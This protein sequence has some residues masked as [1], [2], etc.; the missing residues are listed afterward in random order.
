MANLTLTPTL[1]LSGRGEL[2]RRERGNKEE[3]R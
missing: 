1:S 2:R 3:M